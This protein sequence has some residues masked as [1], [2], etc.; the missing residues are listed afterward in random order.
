MTLKEAKRKVY[1]LLDEYSADGEVRLDG[2]IELR[3]NSFFDMCQKNLAAL[4]PIR[5]L[6]EAQTGEFIPDGKIIKVLAVYDSQG[7]RI[8]P[9]MT[10]N[11]LILPEGARLDLLTL[12][13]DINDD[14]PETYEFEIKEALQECM[15]YWVA[16]SLCAV[17]F[18]VSPAKLMNQFNVMVSSAVSASSPY[19]RT[20]SVV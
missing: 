14:T 19:T 2:D 15:P 12:P 17:D 8:Y 4:A 16:A 10:G 1:G 20:V 6:T 11:V 18:T 5:R 13:S 7:E 9:K 3:L